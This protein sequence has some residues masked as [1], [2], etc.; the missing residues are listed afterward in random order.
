MSIQKTLKLCAIGALASL[1]LADQAF[2][3]N[4]ATAG[5]MAS[6]VFKQFRDFANVITGGAMLA[7]I[8]IGVMAAI[9]LKNHAENPQQ[10]KLTKP[11][12]YFI[13][14]GALIGLPSFLNT[15]KGTLGL[16]Q[17]NSVGDSVYSKI[18]GGG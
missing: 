6:G 9:K 16:N 17:G 14:A 1:A 2:A 4:A 8:G 15:G 11:I 18:G 13:V 10:E 5:D 7:G 3:Q 12:I